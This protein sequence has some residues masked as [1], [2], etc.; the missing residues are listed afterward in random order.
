MLFE[1][2]LASLPCIP[3]T[4]RLVYEPV[5]FFQTIREISMDTLA[6]SQKFKKLDEENC[7]QYLKVVKPGFA[8][9]APVYRVGETPGETPGETDLPVA[10]QS[11][12][13]PKAPP[14]RPTLAE[15]SLRCLDPKRGVSSAGFPVIGKSPMTVVT[16][17]SCSCC[18]AIIM[19]RADGT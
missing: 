3:C 18:C 9:L 11:D 12:G 15:V 2:D 16:R 10:Q 19:I 5:M 6:A 1:H 7:S 17:G 13:A 4:S 8:P 14:Q